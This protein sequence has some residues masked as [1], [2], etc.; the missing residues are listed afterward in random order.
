MGFKRVTAANTDFII[1]VLFIEV[2]VGI[3]RAD[4]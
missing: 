3:T 2:R 4:E 1:E